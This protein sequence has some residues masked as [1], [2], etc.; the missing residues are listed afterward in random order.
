MAPSILQIKNST[1]IKF[2][3]TKCSSAQSSGTSKLKLSK[4]YFV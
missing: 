3:S 4:I 2:G 1:K